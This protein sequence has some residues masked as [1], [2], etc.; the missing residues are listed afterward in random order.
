MVVNGIIHGISKTEVLSELKRRALMPFLIKR[1]GGFF[2]HPKKLSPKTLY[3]F[4]GRLHSMVAGGLDIHKSLSLIANGSTKDTALV[5]AVRQISLKIETGYSLPEAFTYSGAFPS[6]FIG[7][8]SIGQQSGK[9][10]ECLAELSSYY[11]WETATKNDVKSALTY[12]A[13]ICCFMVAACVFALTLIIPAYAEIFEQS[14]AVLP[15]ATRALLAFGSFLHGSNFILILL[16]FAIIVFIYLRLNKKA[17]NFIQLHMPV[18]GRIHR[19]LLNYRLAH[20]ASVLILSGATVSVS[21][22]GAFAALN[23]P[24]LDKQFKEI[25]NDIIK[26]RNISSSFKKVKYFDEVLVNMIETGEETGNL[27]TMFEAAANYHKNELERTVR[28]LKTLIEPILTIII[29]VV[30]CALLMAVILPS[31]SIMDGF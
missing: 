3:L 4:A 5:D 28:T 19:L 6:F 24:Y 18:G 21:L 26:G 8:I 7:M 15:A 20:S 2:G 31:F 10:C 13:I 1:V 25:Q 14:G 22:E 17:N 27:P 11:E 12:P 16:I 29:G 9:L 30:L 23:A